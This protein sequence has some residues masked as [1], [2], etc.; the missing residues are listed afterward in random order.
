MCYQLP[1]ELH[2]LTRYILTKSICVETYP[3]Q[4]YGVSLL[5]TGTFNMR[6]TSFVTSVSL[7]CVGRKTDTKWSFWRMM[8]SEY[9]SPSDT[10][11]ITWTS[12]TLKPIWGLLVWTNHRKKAT[13]QSV[14]REHASFL[15]P[16]W[17]HLQNTTEEGYRWGLA[18]GIGSVGPFKL[19]LGDWCC[20]LYHNIYSIYYKKACKWRSDQRRCQ[21]GWYS[22]PNVRSTSSCES[23][24]RM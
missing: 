15:T 24:C 17:S 10:Y 4:S 20:H 11:S 22:T 21:S 5:R 7:S 3:K 14:T 18:L 8:Y 9:N 6:S 13:L 1:E 12:C 23:A 2:I 16:L 19:W